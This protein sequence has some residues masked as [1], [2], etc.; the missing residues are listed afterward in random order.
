MRLVV[1]MLLAALGTLGSAPEASATVAPKNGEVA[2]LRADLLNLSIDGSDDGADFLVTLATWQIAAP[3]DRLWNKSHP[4]WPAAERR[5]RKDL[6]PEIQEMV[7]FNLT[8]AKALW[9]KALA[10]KLTESDISDLLR[11][12]RSA[13]GKRYTTFQRQLDAICAPTIS[14]ITHSIFS[15]HGIDY[16]SGSP[17]P[18][19]TIDARVEILAMSLSARMLAQT[20][21]DN[22]TPGVQGGQWSI[23]PMIWSE[24]VLT[25][26]SDLDAL[27]IQYAPDLNAFAAFTASPAIRKVMMA[28]AELQQRVA[29]DQAGK[30]TAS[31]TTAVTN[32]LPIWKAALS[33][34]I[35][36]GDE[37][38]AAAEAAQPEPRS[39]FAEWANAQRMADNAIVALAESANERRYY[40]VTVNFELDGVERSATSTWWCRKSE[41]SNSA[42]P[43][44]TTSSHNVVKQISSKKAIFFSQPAECDI[45]DGA[46]YHAWLGVFPDLTDESVFEFY[47]AP[48]KGVRVSGAINLAVV[49]QLTEAP[50]PENLSSLE[51]HIT[52]IVDHHIYDY[53]A[54]VGKVEIEQE[55]RSRLAAATCSTLEHTTT[56]ATSM[57]LFKSAFFPINRDTLATESGRSVRILNPTFAGGTWTIGQEAS[58]ENLI[59]FTTTTALPALMDSNPRTPIPI[60]YKGTTATLENLLEFFDPQNKT[61][62]RVEIDYPLLGSMLR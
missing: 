44:W 6:S 31:L 27:R 46:I 56:T 4:Q 2:E 28:S 59:R 53:K 33:E 41:S 51:T 38:A 47:P 36:K 22:E 10:E 34:S 58:P 49:H 50:P 7:A 20:R 35:K 21:A 57:E 11:F 13:P 42:T 45:E 37:A 54:L 52:T 48:G 19:V 55:W 15:G 61:I 23:Q 30:K 43:G 29:T 32:H 24:T 1:P 3:G 62:I 8:D 17:P 16:P 14:R 26:G 18:P 9:D 12:L 5:V 25:K 60:D 40:S 39:D